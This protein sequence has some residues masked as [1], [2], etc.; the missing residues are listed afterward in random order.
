MSEGIIVAIIGAGAVIAAAVIAKIPIS[1]KNTDRAN[2]GTS[3]NQ[4]VQGDN[5]TIIG[6][7]NNTTLQVG[8]TPLNGG[9]IVITGGDAYDGGKIEYEPEE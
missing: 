4:Q 6:T 8:D 3:I 1:K 9:T 5:N 7:Q 2:H